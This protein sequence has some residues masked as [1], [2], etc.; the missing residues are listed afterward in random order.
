MDTMAYKVSG[1]TIFH[2][3]PVIKPPLI[4]SSPENP[5]IRVDGFPLFQSI[6]VND[7]SGMSQNYLAATS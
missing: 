3:I 7:D 5:D 1:I 4:R 6:L 2:D